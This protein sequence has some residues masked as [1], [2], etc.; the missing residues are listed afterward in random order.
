MAT[1]DPLKQNPVS[2][3]AWANWARNGCFWFL[4][5]ILAWAPFPLGS[6]REWSWSLLPLLVAGCWLLWT[7]TGWATPESQWN[8]L[9]RLSVPLVLAGLTLLWATIQGLPIVPPGWVHPV[10]TDTANLLHRAVPQTISLN[11]WKTLGDVTKLLT[12][13]AVAWIAFCLTQNAD[14]AGKLFNAIIAIGAA[15]ALYAFVLSLFGTEQ[16]LLFYSPPGQASYLSGPFVLHNSFATFEGLAVI[17]ALARL[18]ELAHGEIL[19]SKGIRRWA[20]T[21]LQFTFGS[22]RAVVIATILTV[23]ALIASASR[24]G[25]FSTLCALIA[26]VIPFAFL[27]KRGVGTKWILIGIGA[28]LSLLIIL[29]WISGDTLTSRYEDLIDAG[30]AD[31]IRLALWAAAERMV[32]DTPFLGLGLGTFQDAYPM[33][34]T[35]VLPYILDKAHGDYLEFAAGLGLPAALA[36]WSAILWAAIQMGRGIFSRRRDRIYP[37][38][39]FG[40]T[41]LV[42]VHSSV[43]FSLQIPAVA[44]IYAA[45]L[46]IGLAQSYSTQKSSY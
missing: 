26:M 36:W 23:S 46:G 15:Y 1:L 24:A 13:I 38:V 18:V 17:A 41:I 21:T 43:D 22:G 34:A 35:R 4:V 40:A 7:I 14:R 37:L 31:E 5:A 9:K 2:V 8:N 45:I 6:N 29:V 33:Y 3:P 19:A 44:V 20:S 30:N 42:A 25:C 27:L 28:V 32:A 39:G 12:Y 10:W 11:P 16:Y